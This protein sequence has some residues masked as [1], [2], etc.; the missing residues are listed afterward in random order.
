MALLVGRAVIT[1]TSPAQNGEGGLLRNPLSNRLPIFIVQRTI[2]IM[3]I[4]VLVSMMHFIKASG[5]LLVPVA[6]WV[7]PPSAIQGARSAWANIVGAS[8]YRL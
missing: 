3:Y 5:W 1:V 6:T 4:L 8:Q 2:N 7:Q